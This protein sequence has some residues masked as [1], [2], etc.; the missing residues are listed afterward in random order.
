MSMLKKFQ[1]L[2]LDF[3]IFFIQTLEFCSSG[4]PFHSTKSYVKQK[5]RCLWWG[6]WPAA[7]ENSAFGV[8]SRRPLSFSPTPSLS[9]KHM[10]DPHS[11]GV[12]LKPKGKEHAYLWKTLAQRALIS[13]PALS[14]HVPLW[15][16]F[17]SMYHKHSCD[18]LVFEGV[19]SLWRSLWEMKIY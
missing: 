17:I 3:I 9:L 8:K 12:L 2:G 18:L 4:V 11:R 16:L 14:S 15:L 7:A 19:R 5:I 1:T 6:L 13:L 10:Q